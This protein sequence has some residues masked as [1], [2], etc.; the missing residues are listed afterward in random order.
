MLF[1]RH[2]GHIHR[3]VARRLGDDTAD[4]V[5]SETFLTAFRQ[6]RDY[7]TARL[8]ALPWLYGIATNFI[9]RH[10][11]TEIHRYKAYSKMGVLPDADDSA[12]QA[13]ERASAH[14]VRRPLAQAL[15]S[16]KARDRDVLLL[17]AWADLTYEEVANALS[18]P[19]GTVRSRLNRA[20]A[21]VRNAL[22]STDPTTE[23]TS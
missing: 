10:Q 13:L 4:D 21:I 11:R 7:D 1:D 17:V 14:A 20:R 12:E 5:V 9:R 3:Y 22:G 6:R 15:A 8:G 23:Q 19:I 16:L 18:I 2:A